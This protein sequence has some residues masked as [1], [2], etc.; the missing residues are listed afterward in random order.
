[1]CAGHSFTSE[2][3]W[4]A[5]WWSSKI[6]MCNNTVSNNFSPAIPHNCVDMKLPD[7]Y[8]EV[9]INVKLFEHHIPAFQA[10]RKDNTLEC[11][12]VYTANCDCFVIPYPLYSSHRTLRGDACCSSCSQSSSSEPRL[13]HRLP[14]VL[15]ALGIPATQAGA[16]V[17]CMRRL[18][19]SGTWPSCK[20]CQ[21]AA[22]LLTGI[23]KLV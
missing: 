5:N 7:F 11:H 22:V 21:S 3:W 13:L 20:L 8:S 23:Q 12:D 14:P 9:W 19:T 17:G 16:T 1:M 4:L 6:G 15:S 2:E 18:W 10:K